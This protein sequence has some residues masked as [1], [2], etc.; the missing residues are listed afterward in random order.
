VHPISYRTIDSQSERGQRFKGPISWISLG[1]PPSVQDVAESLILVRQRGASFTPEGSQGAWDRVGY[2]FHGGNER[3]M[4]SEALVQLAKSILGFWLPRAV[5]DQVNGID[6]AVTGQQARRT[7]DSSQCT[8]STTG[9]CPI[10]LDPVCKE[11]ALYCG[12][13]FCRQ[14]II[15]Y[16]QHNGK[17]C[18]M[19]RQRLCME[20]SPRTGDDATATD[21]YGS[22]GNLGNMDSNMGI[23]E[24]AQLRG[25]SA[26]PGLGGDKDTR[27][28]L[29]CFIIPSVAKKLN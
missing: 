13:S 28:L 18:P 14:C 26:L 20:I 11:T 2:A 24:A 12:H 7:D 4:A 22:G 15:A 5:Q 6:E 9:E 3:V 17:A 19:C 27:D 16:G 1:G 29:E 23:R 25:L 8:A 10:C 21:T